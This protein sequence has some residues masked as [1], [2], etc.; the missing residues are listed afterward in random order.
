MNRASETY[1]K[2]SSIISAINESLRKGEERKRSR[3]KLKE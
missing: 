3:N 1:E 2:P